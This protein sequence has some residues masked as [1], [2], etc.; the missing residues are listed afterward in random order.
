MNHHLNPKSTSCDSQSTDIEVVIVVEAGMV[1]GV[2]EAETAVTGL[3]VVNDINTRRHPMD[4][5]LTNIL[6]R[7]HRNNK[8]AYFPPLSQDPI[9]M[10]RPKCLLVGLFKQ[11]SNRLIF[12]GPPAE[13]NQ[14]QQ[15]AFINPTQH[16]QHSWTSPSLL[17]VQQPTTIPQ[18]FHTIN[19]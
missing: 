10:R 12:F 1:A 2:G 6:Y 8:H 15:Q 14:Q 19:E 18:A 13:S 16:Y 3:V 17:N 9:N 11:A 7:V 5:G 4:G